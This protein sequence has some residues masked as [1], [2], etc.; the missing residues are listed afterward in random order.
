MSE[1]TLL[2]VWNMT[3][4]KLI[5]HNPLRHMRDLVTMPNGTLVGVDTR[6]SIVIFDPKTGV[7]IKIMPSK[8]WPKLLPLS[9][10]LLAYLS[11][12]SIVLTDLKPVPSLDHQTISRMT[13]RGS[14]IAG[15][16]ASEVFVGTYHGEIQAW[17]L[18]ESKLLYTLT[19]G[20]SAEISHMVLLPNTKI[21][22]MSSAKPEIL[23]WNIAERKIEFTPTAPNM[24]KVRFRFNRPSLY[25]SLFNVCFIC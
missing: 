7:A 4:G 14:C 10:E 21:A 1:S 13:Y 25:I 19:T 11:E 9:D 24:N 15:E 16:S 3:T 8:F 5:S 6:D 17:N 20:S 23:I 2:P 22:S 12:G 18:L